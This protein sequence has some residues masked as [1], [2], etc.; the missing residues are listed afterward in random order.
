ML[1]SV[2]R[3][4][5]NCSVG[6]HCEQATSS[7]PEPPA[8]APST[9]PNPAE[10]GET[11]AHTA[12]IKNLGL[13]YPPV[14]SLTFPVTRAQMFSSVF[15]HGNDCSVGRRREQAASGIPEPPAHAPS[16]ISTP[17]EKDETVAHAA[18]I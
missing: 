7:V 18:S 17:A 13:T 3:A 11:G 10:I 14:S 15:R 16:T 1:S 12:P 4:G 5:H 9:V 2:R 6:P 8:H